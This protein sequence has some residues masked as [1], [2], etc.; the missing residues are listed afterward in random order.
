MPN[1]AP[2]CKG[3]STGVY[4]SI[5]QKNYAFK[6]VKQTVCIIHYG[7]NMGLYLAWTGT[8]RQTSTKHRNASKLEDNLVYSFRGTEA[9]Q[10]LESYRLVSVSNYADLCFFKYNIC[11]HKFSILEGFKEMTFPNEIFL[12]W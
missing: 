8:L 7:W 3:L 4:R 6:A 5:M 11:E 1:P 9:S 10:V 2:I 12:C